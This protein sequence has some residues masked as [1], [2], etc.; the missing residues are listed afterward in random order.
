MVSNIIEDTF[1]SFK[2]IKV[3]NRDALYWLANG[4]TI[5]VYLYIIQKQDFIRVNPQ[6]AKLRKN[7]K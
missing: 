3:P 1:Y 6:P 4:I 7:V 2:L 5:I